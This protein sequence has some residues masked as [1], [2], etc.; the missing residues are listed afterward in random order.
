MTQLMKYHTVMANP[1]YYWEN[2]TVAQQLRDGSLTTY[3]AYKDAC[4]S[5]GCSCYNE[6]CYD[7]H[8]QGIQHQ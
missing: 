2:N 1:T 8:V 5:A 3:N 6:E 7:N 4:K